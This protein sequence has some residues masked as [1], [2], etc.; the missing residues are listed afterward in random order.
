MTS[1]TPKEKLKAFDYFEHLPNGERRSLNDLPKT[2]KEAEIPTELKAFEKTIRGI[3]GSHTSAMYGATV[4]FMIGFSSLAV[5]GPTV[6]QMT[7]M[8]KTAKMVLVACPCATGSL[9][10]M[11]YG[12]NIAKTGG[13][14]MGT[15]LLFMC[16]AGMLW[17]LAFILFVDPATVEDWS[18]KYICWCFGG[19]LSGFGIAYFPMTINVLFWS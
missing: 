14:K 6:K 15:M 19:L 18:V 4:A 2:V 3:K 17:N 1:K 13:V 8:T 11:I 7:A 10:R 16:L 5:F 9:P 12:G